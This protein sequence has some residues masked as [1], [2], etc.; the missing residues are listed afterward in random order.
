MPY[1]R[2]VNNED[3]NFILHDGVQYP[4]DKPKSS[5]NLGIIFDSQLRLDNHIESKI[6]RAYFVLAEL[7]ETLDI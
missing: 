1:G 2:N 3:I 7:N 5:N 4:P 6:N